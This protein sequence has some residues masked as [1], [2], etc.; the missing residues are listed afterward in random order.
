MNKH[1]PQEESARILAIAI[2]A[3]SGVSRR[4]AAQAAPAPIAPKIPVG[5]QPLR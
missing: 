2:V 3:W 5:C 4:I 1:V